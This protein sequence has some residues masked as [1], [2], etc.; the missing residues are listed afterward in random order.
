MEE[1]PA[2]SN[3]ES[4]GF[5]ANLIDVYFEPRKGFLEILRKPNFW[6]PLAAIVALNVAF[7]GYWMQKVEPKA[8]I[9]AQIDQSGR[10][11]QIPADRREQIVSTQERILPIIAWVSAVAGGPILILVVGA[12]FLFVFRF[13]YA[14]EIRYG[15]SLAVVAWSFFSVA[16]IQIPLLLVVLTLKGDWT[17]NPQTAL[18]ANLSLLLDHQTA[19]HALYSLAQSLDLFSFWIIFLLATG[20]AVASRKTTGSA[21]AGVLIPWA[22][23]VAIK[24]GWV[25]LFG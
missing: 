11:D 25:A 10:A 4:R 15:G 8:F 22:L 13:F 17:I 12:V 5:F 18:Q 1:Q 3:G 2:V 23:V 24:V 6:L 21:L 7:T 20:Y 19:N 16:L 9:E 14:A